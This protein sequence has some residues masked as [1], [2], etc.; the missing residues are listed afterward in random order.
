MTPDPIAIEAGSPEQIPDPSNRQ[1]SSW[2]I[3]NAP[4][5]YLS[6]V[7]YQAGSA[8][9]SFASVWLLTHFLGSTGYGGIVAIIAASQV[10]QVFVNWTS[11]S[12]IRF[13]VDEFI[14]TGRIARIF[15]VRLII[16]SANFGLMAVMSALWFPPLAEWLKL[17]PGL[18]WVVVLHFAITIFW[19]HVQS[20]FQGVKMPRLNGLLMMIERLIIFA[21]LLAILAA[22]ALTGTTAIWCYIAAP[23][24]MAGVGLFR[25][26]HFIFGRFEVDR[27]FIRDV[28]LYS[29]PLAPMALVGYFSGS[30]LDAIFVS[31]LLSTRDLGIY[32]VASQFNG[33]VLQLPTIANSLLTPLFITLV[34]ERGSQRIDRFFH[35]VLPSATLV[36]SYVCVLAAVLGGITIPI[37]FGPEFKGS[38]VPFWILLAASSVGVPVLIGYAALSNAVSATYISM[39][40]AILAALANIVF[41]VLLI[42]R[43]GLAGCAVA[44]LI[45]LAASVTTF[46]YFVKQKTTV[47]ISWL[48]AAFLPAASGVITFFVADSWL[49]ALGISTM[50]VIVEFFI[51]RRSITR[52][53]NFVRAVA[54]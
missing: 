19:I 51:F 11:Y 47:P 17:Q 45:S 43:Y 5:N 18:R 2:D 13:G 32:S 1:S 53:Y 49:P 54:A 33:I 22:N 7:I 28:V 36:W 9:L 15:W 30:Y 20:T 35:D 27:A 3:S 16:M 6:L 26:R 23:A 10:A 14:E 8:I 31:D 39:Y 48:P 34:K 52:S 25:L 46:A 29:L 50:A 4:R 24:A 42:P 41:D 40:A 44:T 12:V 38:V 21:G 37:L